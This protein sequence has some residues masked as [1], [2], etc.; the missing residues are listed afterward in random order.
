M[1]LDITSTQFFKDTMPLFQRGDIDTFEQVVLFLQNGDYNDENQRVLLEKKIDSIELKSFISELLKKNNN[2]KLNKNDIHSVLEE[3]IEKYF[4]EKKRYDRYFLQITKN[5][6]DFLKQINNALTIENEE[7]SIEELSQTILDRLEKMREVINGQLK[8]RDRFSLNKQTPEIISRSKKIFETLQKQGI[9]L[10]EDTTL[11]GVL[12][13]KAKNILEEHN[14]KTN[15][16]GFDTREQIQYLAADIQAS[17]VAF[18]NIKNGMFDNSDLKTRLEKTNNKEDIEELPSLRSKSN[19]GEDL[20]YRIKSNFTDLLVE[21]SERQKR[22]RGVLSKKDKETFKKELSTDEQFKQDFRSL[23]SKVLKVSHIETNNST[24]SLFLN[25]TDVER[26][27]QFAVDKDLQKSFLNITL[28][29]EDNN[30]KVLKLISDFSN[31][32]SNTILSSMNKEPLQRRKELKKLILEE[33][34]ESKLKQMKRELSDIEQI[35][36]DFIK[37]NETYGENV[38]DNI[39][40]EFLKT[41]NHSI[42][43]YKTSD[44]IIENLKNN[45]KIDAKTAYSYDEVEILFN[46]NEDF[47]ELL[48][49]LIFIKDN[50]Q[51]FETKIFCLNPKEKKEIV[52]VVNNFGVKSFKD[53]SKETLE[54]L[55]VNE[56]EITIT[57]QRKVDQL[58]DNKLTNILG[59]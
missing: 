44:N 10:N 29:T 52:N 36:K 31:L 20:F 19:P 32:D 7:I 1:S 56:E 28:S 58:N 46:N 17:A 54:K 25:M 55:K 16:G 6:N 47:S 50:L 43:T 2:D 40:E 18:H 3:V 4:L 45:K 5:K 35:S 8:G 12:S 38:L 33:T 39:E 24:K 48:D 57:I 59:R 21:K 14:V 15:N 53:I 41:L 51:H 49:T 22:T 37:F 42:H 27:T 23:I 26:T 34:N 13:N 9:E 11:K 30:L